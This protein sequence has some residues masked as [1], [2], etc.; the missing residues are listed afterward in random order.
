MVYRSDT[1]RTGK[2]G[3]AYKYEFPKGAGVK[4]D[5]PPHCRPMLPDPSIPLWITEGQKKAD[6]LASHGLCAIALLGVW[7]FK[8]KN[9]FGGTTLLADFDYIALDGRD[10]RIVFDNDVMTKRAVQ[11]ALA[12]L[13][14]HL[15]RRKAHVTT[16]YLPQ[17]RGK[18]VGADDF[19]LTHG[20]QD[21]E[22]LVEQPRPEP[23]P[24][25][26][27]INLLPSAP[28]RLTR[29]LMLIEGQAYAATWLWTRT[30]ITEKRS[31]KGE[32][33]K[34]AE[35]EV[36]DAHRLFVMR[37]DGTLFGEVSDPHVLPMRDVGLTVHLPEVPRET[38]LWSASG[39]KAY[40][41]GYRADAPKVFERV[42]NVVDRFIDFNKSLADQ[43]T[44]A[45]CV[46]CYILST[47]F[48]TP[49]R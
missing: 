48:W 34:L 21:L 12:R 15:Q 24:A 23:Q 49:S 44:M 20:V 1:P 39:V 27:I 2:D 11:Q 9:P 32:I 37:D 42:V 3:R 18:K 46:G 30:T 35:P 7:N 14:E 47:Y 38:R 16:V 26:P 22:G 40:H 13:T 45:E 10:V 25:A 41:M 8:G 19:L 33:T 4:L 6:A 5:C 43:R 29:P 31:K 28:Q 17:D 36:T